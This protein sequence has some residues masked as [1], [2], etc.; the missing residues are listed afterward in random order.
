MKE[1]TEN[2]TISRQTIDS[3]KAPNEILYKNENT[4]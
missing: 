3:E 1:S 4:R 2:I